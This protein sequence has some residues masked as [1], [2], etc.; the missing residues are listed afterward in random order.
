M[1]S[2]KICPNQTFIF[3]NK[4]P[5]GYSKVYGI[6]ALWICYKASFLQGA[7]TVQFLA[8]TFFIQHF[9]YPFLHLGDASV[10]SIDC[11]AIKSGAE[12]DLDSPGKTSGQ[13]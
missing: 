8:N 5:G 12:L 4:P 6:V 1:L 13:L 3:A 11:F 10:L 2:F 9:E 7:Q